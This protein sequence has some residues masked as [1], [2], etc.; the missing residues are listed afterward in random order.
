VWGWGV[1]FEGRSPGK[2]LFSLVDACGI[3][4]ASAGTCPRRQQQPGDSFAHTRPSLPA[5]SPVCPQRERERE[6]PDKLIGPERV[7]T[8]RNP[9]QLGLT[10]RKTKT[11]CSPPR[12][13]TTRRRVAP[14]SGGV[15]NWPQAAM[16]SRPD[17]VNSWPQAATP[18]GAQPCRQVVHLSVGQTNPGFGTQYCQTL[19]V[20]VICSKL[21]DLSGRPTDGGSFSTCDTFI[22][23]LL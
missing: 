23:Q 19:E 17:G 4:Y 14:R 2:G 18:C 7:P 21:R 1:L 10:C 9:T 11:D 12:P 20:W 13:V 22:K 5:P 3:G 15:N 8:V 6:E 16:P